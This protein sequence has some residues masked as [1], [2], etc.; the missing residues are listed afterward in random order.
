MTYTH[1]LIINEEYNININLKIWNKKFITPHLRQKPAREIKGI[2]NITETI[3]IYV[4]G[5]AF[6]V[7]ISH[8]SSKCTSVF[9]NSNCFCYILIPVTSLAGFWHRCGIINFWFYIS[10]LI[11]MLYYSLNIWSINFTTSKIFYLYYKDSMKQLT[12]VNIGVN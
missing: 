2:E 9:R 4:N 11:F 5:V 1:R 3:W 6:G 10:K 8:V 7:I 12:I